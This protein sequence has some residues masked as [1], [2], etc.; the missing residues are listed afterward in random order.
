MSL[1]LRYVFFLSLILCG[2]KRNDGQLSEDPKD[3]F[4]MSRSELDPFLSA[5]PE[6]EPYRKDLI[7]LYDK[8]D[9]RM[10]W[11]D[12]DGRVDFAEVLYDQAV[13]LE[14]EGVP[15]DLPYKSEID[16][17]IDK[18]DTKKP[19]VTDELLVSSMYF[20]YAKKALSGLDARHSRSTGWFLPRDK[21][22]YVA[23]LDTL[24]K[25][26]E[27]LEKQTEDRFSQYNRLRAALEKYRKLEQAGGWA[28]I[29]FR[30]G[31]KALKRGD[32]DP[33]VA[34]VRKRLA[35]SGDLASDSKSEEFDQELEQAIQ[36][37]QLRH[38]RSG[39]QIDPDLVS[40]LNVPVSERIKTLVV[41]LER[42]RW[43]PGD[44]EKNEEYVFVNI[45]AFHLNYVKDSR[46][47]LES[48]V[49]V[50]K[51]MNKTVVFSGKMS[52]L[53]FAPYWNIPK[54]IVKKEIAPA[55]A[56]DR[57]YLEKHNME[58]Y[59]NGNIRQRPGADNSLGLVK[60]MFPNTNNIY[61]HDTPAKAL[62][63]KDER[64]L[65]HGCVRVQKAK[66]LANL[67][68]QDDKKWSAERIDQAMH[69]G[70]ETQYSLDRKIPVY[71]AY[72]TAWADQDGNV[73]F[74]D[75]IYNRDKRLAGLLYKE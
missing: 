27:S 35:F 69:S 32:S 52:Y 51:E 70:K 23:Y 42:C 55:L 2:C 34:Q 54:S 22:S 75:D 18:R 68:L 45:P 28:T 9:H 73:A 67:I 65:S 20:F 53:V 7:A 71:L 16:E 38:F 58:Y 61:L 47:A 50:G 37:Y 36:A 66:E 59:G 15:V 21:V 4:S 56:K 74:F 46:L 13:Q 40:Q 24:L 17:V 25:S 8:H 14:S 44:F 31:K 39:T 10:I 26:P 33:V 43:I 72:F 63:N 62:F 49:V 19:S 1:K 30:K 5:H 11:Y 60:F 41:N 3:R 6:F 29:D 57:R 12:K 64:A 48:N